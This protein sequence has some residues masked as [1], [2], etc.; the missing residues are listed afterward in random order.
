MQRKGYFLD[1]EKITFYQSTLLMLISIIV[2]KFLLL[3]QINQFF[4]NIRD[5]YILLIKSLFEIN[6][7]FFWINFR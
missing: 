1:L 7:Y 4:M 3:N 6:L 5:G 2:P